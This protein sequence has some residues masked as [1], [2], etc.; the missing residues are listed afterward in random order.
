MSCSCTVKCGNRR[1][2]F[3]EMT[4]C[5]HRIM[6][7]SG[8]KRVSRCTTCTLVLQK[9]TSARGPHATL[10]RASRSFCSS[11]SGQAKRTSLTDMLPEAILSNPVRCKVMESRDVEDGGESQEEPPTQARNQ[12]ALHVVTELADERARRVPPRGRLAVLAD[13]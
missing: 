4:R 9:I 5:L 2:L 6:T 1:S 10:P 11:N 3:D 8:K 12:S 13:P 7:T